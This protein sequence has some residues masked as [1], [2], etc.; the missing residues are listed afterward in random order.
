M[1]PVVFYTFSRDS[2][3]FQRSDLLAPF[4]NSELKFSRTGKTDKTACLATSLGSSKH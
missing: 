3:P 2:P 1:N 4:P